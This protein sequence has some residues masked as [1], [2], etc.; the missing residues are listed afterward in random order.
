MGS[1][2]K[3]VLKWLAVAFLV[4]YLFT[5]PSGSADAVTGLIDLLQQGAE[6][7]VTFFSEIGG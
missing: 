6:A 5:N 2:S 1:N 4:F 7:V 3:K